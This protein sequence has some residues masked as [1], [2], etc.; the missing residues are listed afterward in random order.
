MQRLI[1]TLAFAMVLA[2]HAHADPTW[3]TRAPMPTPRQGLA[4]ATVGGT[5][6]AI[7]GQRY[8]SLILM[9]LA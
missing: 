7:G 4:V 5:I 9:M 3:V 1:S 2:T 6:Y 8:G